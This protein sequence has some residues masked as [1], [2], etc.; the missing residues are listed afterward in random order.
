MKQ[1]ERGRERENVQRD[2]E[3]ITLQIFNKIDETPKIV[4]IMILQ[5]CYGN[6]TIHQPIVEGYKELQ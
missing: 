1:R 2:A 5:K 3:R 4:T 6:G